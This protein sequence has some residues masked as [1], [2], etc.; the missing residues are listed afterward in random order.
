MLIDWFTVG[1]QA[2]NFLVLVWLLKRFL[3]KPVLAA[4]AAREERVA[5][6]VASAEADRLKTRSERDGLAGKLAA[7]EADR[8]AQKA[9]AVREA[10]IEKDRL[11][12]AARQAAVDL[13][14]DDASALRGE[15]E[16]LGQE[17]AQLATRE[18]ARVTRQALR[19][20]A[21]ATLEQ[22]MVAEFLRRLAHLVPQTREAL[23]AGLRTAGAVALVRSSAELPPA[24]R[25]SLKDGLNRS[26][27]ADVPVSFRTDAA[28]ICGIEL[29]LGGQRVAWSVAEYLAGLEREAVALIRAQTVA[30]GAAA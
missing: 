13:R 2:F 21:G 11:L 3:Y 23:S 28:V 8:E 5:A 29:D 17:V 6:E 26:L 22:E 9:Q 16:R 10:G 24:A 19:D 27:S 14:R 1:A 18:V 15:A 7:F 20:L 4:I 12:A 30:P 25:A